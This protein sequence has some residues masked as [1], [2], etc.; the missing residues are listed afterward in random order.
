MGK[1]SGEG[2]GGKESSQ[3]GVCFSVNQKGGDGKR[4]RRLD[5]L[6]S[7]GVPRT[8]LTLS[9]PLPRKA[10]EIRFS[11]QGCPSIGQCQPSLNLYPF[12]LEARE[13]AKTPLSSKACATWRE[14]V[15]EEPKS[16]A[17]FLFLWPLRTPQDAV[18]QMGDYRMGPQAFPGLGA[19]PCPSTFP[20]LVLTPFCPSCSLP[21]ARCRKWWLVL[22]CSPTM[23][24]LAESRGVH[25]RLVAAHLPYKALG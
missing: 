11:I 21:S 22:V 15:E 25:D 2:A 17:V 16:R 14:T 9:V 18:D 4:T 6:P 24:A 1:T 20:F 5:G 7:P 10:G 12:G 3:C 23:V 8:L 13:V 19:G